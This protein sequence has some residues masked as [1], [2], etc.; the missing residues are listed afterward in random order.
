MGCSVPNT[1]EKP[2]FEKLTETDSI[3]KIISTLNTDIQ[4][5]SKKIDMFDK[6][7]VIRKFYALLNGLS[8]GSYQNITGSLERIDVSKITKDKL[9]R[10]FDSVFNF[11]YSKTMTEIFDDPK[12]HQEWIEK[13]EIESGQ[14]AARALKRDNSIFVFNNFLITKVFLETLRN[15]LK[16]KC[17]SKLKDLIELLISLQFEYYEVSSNRSFNANEKY[18]FRYRDLAN[19]IVKIIHSS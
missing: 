13:M 17:P 15:F 18:D 5:L 11:G 12:V 6:C 19:K 8:F 9:L 3:E 16:A 7:T 1:V 14:E 2:T 10:E 4:F